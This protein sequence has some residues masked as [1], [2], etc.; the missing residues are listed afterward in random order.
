MQI[1]DFFPQYPSQFTSNM[2]F[3]KRLIL[4]EFMQLSI[5]LH[6]DIQIQINLGISSHF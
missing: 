2:Q 6:R 3:S 1:L 4:I 5:P